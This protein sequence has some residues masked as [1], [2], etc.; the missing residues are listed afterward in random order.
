MVQVVRREYERQ[1]GAVAPGQLLQLLTRHR[2][3]DWLHDLSEMMV[4]IHEMLDHD[5]LTSED[6]R[7]VYEAVEK[8]LAPGESVTSG[9]SARYLAAL[10][11]DPA[12]VIAH[13]GVRRILDAL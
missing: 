2:D 7:A 11:N 10:Q 4:E 13:T 1:W 9:F 8:M 6:V 12:L 5:P 3:F